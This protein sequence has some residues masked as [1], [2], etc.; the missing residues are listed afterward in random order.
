M[1]DWFF[2][3]HQQQKSWWLLKSL[4]LI[5]NYI[6]CLSLYVVG[7]LSVFL[8][9]TLNNKKKTHKNSLNILCLFVFS[10]FQVIIY[11]CTC[12]PV[13]A[14]NLFQ[15]VALTKSTVLWR[16]RH[17]LNLRHFLNS[18]RR[19]PQT[20]KRKRYRLTPN[21]CATSTNCKMWCGHKAADSRVNCKAAP[22]WISTST[23]KWSMLLTRK[24]RDGSVNSSF[25]RSRNSKRW[26]GCWSELHVNIE[27]H[28]NCL[29]TMYICLFE[30]KKWFMC[31]CV[32][33]GIWDTL[34]VFHSRLTKESI[35]LRPLSSS[36]KVPRLI[37]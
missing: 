25:D 28:F 32:N 16:C 14:A 24:W 9:R 3:Y 34:F 30:V 2:A 11:W 13:A 22:M 23:A 18:L 21:S 1:G 12:L 6:H 31:Q 33:L 37:N 7:D 5:P 27:I 35:L 29:I 20:R 4:G 17:W 10:W 36:S 19:Y 8:E 26:D 15:M